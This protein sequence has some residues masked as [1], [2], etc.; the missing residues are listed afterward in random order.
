MEK[1]GGRFPILR[2][3]AMTPTNHLPLSYE[4]VSWVS[5]SPGTNEGDEANQPTRRFHVKESVLLCERVGSLVV[6]SPGK[7]R[8]SHR[9]TNQPP[10][11]FHV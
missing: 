1:R 9:P 2:R 6:H 10:G 7:V 4:R 3:T 11:L 8:E 5:I